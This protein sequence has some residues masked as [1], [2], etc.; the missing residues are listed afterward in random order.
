MVQA[1]I[2]LSQ[3]TNRVLNIVKAKY[4]LHDKGAAIEHIVNEYIDLMNE[5]ELRPEFIKKIKQIQQQKGIK[6]D[7]F[8][9]RYRLN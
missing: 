7:D 2:E 5:P 1:L 6:V 3:N 8:E 4:E 9:K